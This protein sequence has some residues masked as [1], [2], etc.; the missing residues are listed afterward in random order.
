MAS[1]KDRKSPVAEAVDATD[2]RPNDQFAP[3]TVV[4]APIPASWSFGRTHLRPPRVVSGRAGGCAL[5]A[6]GPTRSDRTSFHN[7]RPGVPNGCG[8]TYC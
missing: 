4:S 1:P 5:V 6:A 8:R 2:R 7:A 3:N